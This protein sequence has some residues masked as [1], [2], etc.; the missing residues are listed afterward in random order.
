MCDTQWKHFLDG[1][2]LSPHIEGESEMRLIIFGV[3]AKHTS[4]GF[5]MSNLIIK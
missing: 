5:R 2:L 4:L 3:G 1:L